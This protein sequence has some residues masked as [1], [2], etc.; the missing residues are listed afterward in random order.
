MG[1]NTVHNAF[2]I[3]HNEDITEARVK[4][5][6]QLVKAW[7]GESGSAEKAYEYACTSSCA[8][9]VAGTSARAA[10]PVKVSTVCIK[11]GQSELHFNGNAPFKEIVAMF[12]EFDSYVE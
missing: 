1:A 3:K 2:E 10:D 4:E 7:I 12:K 8:R 9:P 6:Y 11:V 5:I